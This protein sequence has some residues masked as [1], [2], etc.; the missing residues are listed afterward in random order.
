MPSQIE[1]WDHLSS[2]PP[3][4]S[5]IDPLDTRGL[6]NRY[7]TELRNR[8]I[9]ESLARA[10]HHG[11]IVDFGCGTGGIAASLSAPDTPIVGIDISMGLLRRTGERTLAGPAVFVQYDGTRL[12]L[13][14]ASIGAA[15][16]Y[17]V[18][19]HIMD[20]PALATTLG[21]LHRVL[22]PGGMVVAIEQVRRRPTIDP[23]VWQHRRTIAGYSAL[24]R[25]AGFELAGADVIRYGRMPTT[26]ALRFGLVPPRAFALLQ[27][28][29]RALGKLFG[30]VPWDYSDVRFVLRR[31]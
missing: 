2:H 17:V 24:F 20:D 28:A 16:T 25:A 1:H 29:E 26:Y 6:K 12:P 9:R 8:A 23:V 10:G 7:I 22:R 11:A 3:D 30:V 5:V 18:L 31:R 27:R 4:A 15:V 13:A 21:E 14:D 19:T